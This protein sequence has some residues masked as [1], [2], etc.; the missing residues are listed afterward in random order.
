MTDRMVEVA[1]LALRVI[2]QKVKELCLMLGFHGQTQVTV[3][4]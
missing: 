4:T 1:W 3:E 2:A